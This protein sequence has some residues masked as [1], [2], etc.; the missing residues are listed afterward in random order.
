MLASNWKC[1]LHVEEFAFNNYPQYINFVLILFKYNNQ[2]IDQWCKS[3]YKKRKKI[4][5]IE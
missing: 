4:N 5:R 1:L 2:I 3:A